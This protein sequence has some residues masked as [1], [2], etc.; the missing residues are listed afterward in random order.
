[1][2]RERSGF[3]AQPRASGT[4]GKRANLRLAAH[5][6]RLDRVVWQVGSAWGSPRGQLQTVFA[7]LALRRTQ[8]D[9]PSATVT[10]CS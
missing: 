1:V 5:A 6:L 8:F 4:R 9:G 3:D 10:R 2:G 7:E